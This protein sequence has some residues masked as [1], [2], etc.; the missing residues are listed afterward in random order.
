M[1]KL[2]YA[3]GIGLAVYFVWKLYSAY[4]ATKQVS[5]SVQHAVATTVQAPVNTISSV[6][7]AGGFVWDLVRGVGWE[8]SIKV[9]QNTTGGIWNE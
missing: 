7:A 4:R 6:Y 1:K 3:I 5:E 2:L 8:Q 9:Y